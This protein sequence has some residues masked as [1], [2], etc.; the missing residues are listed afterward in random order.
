MFSGRS[1]GSSKK[2]L[3]NIYGD[4]S[5]GLCGTLPVCGVSW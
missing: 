5:K 3:S 1:V 2:R 4:R